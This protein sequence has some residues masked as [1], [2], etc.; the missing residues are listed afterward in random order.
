MSPTFLWVSKFDVK[1]GVGEQN[2]LNYPMYVSFK[3]FGSKSYLFSLYFYLSTSIFLKISKTFFPMY[4]WKSLVL[5]MW[6]FFLFLIEFIRFVEIFKNVN[7]NSKLKK[8]WLQ[9]CHFFFIIESSLFFL[10]KR[11]LGKGV[12]AWCDVN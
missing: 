2:F 3:I 11:A 10:L 12:S 6:L 8:V 1:L 9:T 7:L 4:N 5:N